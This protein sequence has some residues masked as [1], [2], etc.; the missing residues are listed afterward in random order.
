MGK[1]MKNG[2]IKTEAT[3]NQ[4]VHFEQ[5]S[6]CHRIVSSNF[7]SRCRFVVTVPGNVG[8]ANNGTM[9][10]NRV[11]CELDGRSLRSTA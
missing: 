1:I 11:T 10:G 9:T 6:L 3:K 8:A 5:D 4:S 7:T 2:G